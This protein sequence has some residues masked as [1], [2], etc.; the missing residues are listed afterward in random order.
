MTGK[1]ALD[2][3]STVN[4]TPDQNTY[5]RTAAVRPRSRQ[6]I[7]MLL[8]IFSIIYL[9]NWWGRFARNTWLG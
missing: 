2:S 9:V 5:K 8:L 1:G 3:V 4:M 6:V 7:L